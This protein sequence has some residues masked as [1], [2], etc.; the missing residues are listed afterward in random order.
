MTIEDGSDRDGVDGVD[1]VDGVVGDTG[2]DI[3]R[4]GFERIL[5]S[6]TEAG[7]RAASRSGA[8]L[9]RVVAHDPAPAVTTQTDLGPPLV[10]V[11]GPQ[12]G[13][14]PRG[15]IGP[16]RVVAAARSTAVMVLTLVM[17]LSVWLF[18]LEPLLGSRAVLVRDG[19][20]EPSLR[21]GDVAIAARLD[22]TPAVG[23]IVAARIDGRV[24][25]TRVVDR[26]PSAP[27]ATAEQRA[28]APLVLLADGQ[29]LGTGVEVMRED[30]IG[31]VGAAVPRIGLPIAW[32]R[33]PTAAPL[34][35]LLVLVVGGF[36]G[37]GVRQLIRERQAVRRT[38]SRGRR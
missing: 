36:T 9:E 32:L 31:V 21:T 10:P 28:A 25:V 6:L 34:G 3:G 29:A 37:V 19:L 1:D 26:R 18:V 20:M 4:D 2:A 13:E 24:A 33:A 15:T 17:V 30:V 22:G 16:G 35:T 27:G 8:L 7:T 5:H 12:S 23:D 11:P 38:R 14:P